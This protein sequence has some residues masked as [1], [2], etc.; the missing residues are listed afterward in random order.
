MLYILL[1]LIFIVY[2]EKKLLENQGELIMS[3]ITEEQKVQNQKEEKEVLDVV[4]SGFTEVSVDKTVFSYKEL[5]TFGDYSIYLFK[6]PTYFLKNLVEAF[7]GYYATVLNGKYYTAEEFE[8]GAYVKSL[9]ELYED[10][11]NVFVLLREN[12]RTQGKNIDDMLSTFIES[13][14]KVLED[15]VQHYLY[16][17]VYNLFKDQN[18]NRLRERIEKI[19]IKDILHIVIGVKEKGF[20]K[21]LFR[22][23]SSIGLGSVLE[24]FLKDFY[25]ESTRKGNFYHFEEEDNEEFDLIIQDLAEYHYEHER[26]TMVLVRI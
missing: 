16:E 23:H 18:P 15:E 9:E 1:V 25:I 2:I 24:Y 11:D 19:F 5:E 10:N 17:N 12:L 13:I 21:E 7:P 4:Y 6:I 14:Y 26:C 3:F 22:V 20:K 8:A